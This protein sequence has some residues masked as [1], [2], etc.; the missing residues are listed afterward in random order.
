MAVIELTKNNFEKEV[1]K[2][3]IPVIV[4][5]WAVWCGPCRLMSPLF[6]KLSGNK[7]FKGK[8]KFARLDTEGEPGIAGR[9]HILSIPCLIL[10]NNGK[11]VDRII[12]LYPEDMLNNKIKDLIKKI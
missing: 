4:D 11:E 8:L 10:L 7:E 9:F 6:E 5:F 12:G 1:N 2:S 3:K